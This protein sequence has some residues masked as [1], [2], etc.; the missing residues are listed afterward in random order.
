M[1]TSDLDW[2]WACSTISVNAPTTTVTAVVRLI[3]WVKWT[4]FWGVLSVIDVEWWY[5]EKPATRR[6]ELAKK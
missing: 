3:N 5:S 2:L 4:E 6:N 1:S